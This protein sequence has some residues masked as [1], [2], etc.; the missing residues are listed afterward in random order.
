MKIQF[1]QYLLYFF[2]ENWKTPPLATALLVLSVMTFV[3]ISGVAL[4]AINSNPIFRLVFRYGDRCPLS[5][6]GRVVAMAWT[7]F[8]VVLIGMIVG[9]I[10]ASLT[11]VAVNEGGSL[12]GMKV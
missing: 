6:A 5:V 8:G 3:L 4:K 2:G 9:N 1:H 10:A 12:Y 11:T 7:L